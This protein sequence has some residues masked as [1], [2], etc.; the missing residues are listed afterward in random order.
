MTTKP[1]TIDRR[2]VLEAAA[3]ALGLSWAARLV[4]GAAPVNPAACPPVNILSSD[5]AVRGVCA[6]P[7]LTLLPDGTIAAVIYN[8]PCHLTAEGE[9]ECWVT[10]DG[11]KTWT[12]RGTPSPH[13]P[14]TAR[15]NVAAGLAHNGDL[16]VLVSGWGY[17]P[18]F[19]NRR[20]APWVCRSADQGKTW[21]VDKSPS[22][23]FF[24]EG[25]DY[26]D[27][28]QRMIK[29]FGDIVALAGRRLA[30]SFYHDYGSVWVHF[31]N[32]DGR[33]WPEASLLS[34]DHRGETAILR[35]RPDRWLAAARVERGPD[36]KTPPW[37]LGL[38]VSA[39]EG[40][41][42]RPHGSLTEPNQHPGHLLQLKDGR[43]LLTFGMRDVGAIGV[44]VSDDEGRT[45]QPTEV[46]LTLGRGDLGYPATVQTADGALVTAYYYSK[47]AYH[48]GVVRW[49]LGGKKTA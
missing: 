2:T 7:N 48:M 14:K 18:S 35:L 22:A 9:V 47:P 4:R 12:K 44:R 36:E 27:R 10:S 19:R 43:I 11:G 15:A 6:W 25:A 31:S 3:A 23:V 38:F 49:S 28:G 34:S 1:T 39:D 26:D 21:T 29:P 20:L 13:E 45:W 32:D 40:R 17:A 8:R 37:G 41:T 42:W 30:A 46:L 33:T 24:P 5:V 16:V